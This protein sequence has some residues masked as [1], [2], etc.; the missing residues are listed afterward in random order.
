MERRLREAQT[1]IEENKEKIENERKAL[2][3]HKAK[4]KEKYADGRE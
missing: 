4:Q 3:E 2:E 1:F